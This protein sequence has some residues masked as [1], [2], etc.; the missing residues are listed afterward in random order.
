MKNLKLGV[1]LL[2]ALALGAT[3]EVLHKQNHALVRQLNEKTTQLSSTQTELQQIKTRLAAAERQLGFLEKNKTLVQVTAYARSYQSKV[4]A[5]GKSITHAYAVPQHVLPEDKVVNIA[6]SPTAQERLHAR[7]NDYIVLIHKRSHRKTLARFVD[8][9]PSEVRPVV[10][11]FFADNRQAL[12]WGRR[13]DYYAV[14]ISLVNSPF[15]GVLRNEVS[16]Q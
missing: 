12:L 13:T 1:A 10:D 7:M 4:F 14:N 5:D 15:R 3:I 11:V 9:M 16:Q 2:I 6:L 8:L